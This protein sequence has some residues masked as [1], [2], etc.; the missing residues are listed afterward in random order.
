MITLV[1]GPVRSVLV[2]VEVQ[3]YMENYDAINRW[4]AMQLVVRLHMTPYVILKTVNF[5]TLAAISS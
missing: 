4:C 2:S 5:R 3:S 1:V